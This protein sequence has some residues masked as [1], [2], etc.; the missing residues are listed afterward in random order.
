M[1]ENAGIE[2]GAETQ[3]TEAASTESQATGVN[4]AWT[5]ILNSLP[6]S[7]HSQVMPT[8]KKWDENYQ[9]GIQKVHSQ[10]EPYKA[11]LDAGYDPQTLQY[12]LAVLQKLEEDPRAIYDALAEQNGW[13]VEQG[14]TESEDDEVYEPGEVLDPRITRAEQLSE[15]VAEYVMSQHQQQEEDEEDAALDAEINTLREKHGLPEDQIIDRFVM[16]LMLGGMSAEDAF[17]AYVD[18]QS[19]IATRPRAGDKAPIILGS[20]GGVPSSQITSDQIKNPQQ[21]KALVA[22]MIAQAAQQG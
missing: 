18:T 14:Q 17:Q 12:S 16:G 1:G 7:L 15:A 4:P 6:D 11:I 2:G 10:Y 9:Q 5:E 13:A 21:R 20:G 8:L 3:G 19:S 22:Q